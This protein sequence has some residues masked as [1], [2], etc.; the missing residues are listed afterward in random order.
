MVSK[1]WQDIKDDKTV[2]EK[3]EY[4]SLRDREMYSVL[5]KFW[6]KEGEQQAND[7][8]PGPSRWQMK[9]KSRDRAEEPCDQIMKKSRV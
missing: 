4:L 6:K 3:Y 8:N 2:T 9:L 1:S 5:R 7:N